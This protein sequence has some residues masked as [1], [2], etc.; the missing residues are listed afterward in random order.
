MNEE[1][2]SF[3][4]GAPQSAADSSAPVHSRLG[5]MLNAAILGK[6]TAERRLAAVLKEREELYNRVFAL[7]WDNDVLK[8]K[9]RA[10]KGEF[11]PDIVADSANQQSRP[12]QDAEKSAKS[13]K[14]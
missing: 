14:P 7:E 13:A 1:S 9:I 12:V 5:A 10:L 3:D 11:I 4:V 6:T 2:S 8:T